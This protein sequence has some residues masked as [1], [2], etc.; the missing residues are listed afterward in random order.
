MRRREGLSVER[1]HDAV[2]NQPRAARCRDVSRDGAIGLRNF[3]FG[4]G[5]HPDAISYLSIVASVAADLFLEIERASWLPSSALCFCYFVFGATCSDAWSRCG[6]QGE[7]ARRNRERSAGRV[8]D[9][10]HFHRRRA[11]RL[12]EFRFLDNGRPF[13]RLLTAYV[14]CSVRRSECNANSAELMSKPWRMVALHIGAW[15]TSCGRTV[16]DE[17]LI[18]R[19]TCPCR[20]VGC[21]E[22]IVVRLKRIVAALQDRGWMSPQR[23]ANPVFRAYFVIVLVSTF[24]RRRSARVRAFHFE[25]GHSTM[26]KTYGPGLYGRRSA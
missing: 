8:S 20:I 19:L 4:A 24:S 16:S 21:I 25:K 10:G 9:V 1:S 17:V 26:F 6:G 5:I 18:S 11:Q 2:S 13:S 3:V 15:L 23:A 22:T 14:A 7:R 12:D